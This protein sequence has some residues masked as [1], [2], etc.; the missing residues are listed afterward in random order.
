[1]VSPDLGAPLIDFDVLAREVV[2][3]GKPA[4]EEIVEF[5]GRQV[6][7]GDDRIDRKK[8]SEIVFRD[9]EKRK[10]LEA[11]THPRIFEEFHRQVEHIAAKNPDAVIQAG[12]PLLIE[13]NLQYRF[14]KVLLV[15]IPQENQIERVMK[16]DGISREAAVNILKAQIPIEEKVGYADFVIHNERRLE[17]TRKQVEEVWKELKKAQKEKCLK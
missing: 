17:E 16:R 12:I 6:L 9:M 8:L 3:P 10:K 4:W 7:Q 5:F 2:E 11:F 13:L 1:V 14:D 15:Y